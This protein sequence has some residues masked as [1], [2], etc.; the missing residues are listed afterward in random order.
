MIKEK[1]SNN[2]EIKEIQ[3]KSRDQ[4]LEELKNRY[5]NNPLFLESLKELETNPLGETL[6]IKLRNIEDY[7]KVISLLQSKDYK[8]FVEMNFNIFS[9]IKKVIDKLDNIARKVY[10]IES[11]T[12]LI[13]GLIIFFLIFNTIRL[14]IYNYRE[15]I[16][17]MRLVG[18]SSWFISGPFL[19]E[20]IFYGFLAWLINVGILFPLLRFIQPYTEKFLDHYQFNLVSYFSQNFPQIFGGQLLII[21]F[22]SILSSAVAMRKYLKV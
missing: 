17:I 7:P 15:E 18:A 19:L 10:Q 11:I 2:P 16:G 6:I 1:L 14:A 4:A 13:F 9:D 22:I 3:Y 21:I 12:S 20:S 8:D 5:Q